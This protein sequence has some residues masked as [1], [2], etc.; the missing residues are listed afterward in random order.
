M[1]N[2]F[3]F[4]NGGSERVF[5][6]ERDFLLKRGAKVIDFSMNDPRNFPSPYSSFFVSNIDYRSS[7]GSWNRICQGGK[8]IHSPG[9]MEKTKKIVRMEKP[10]IAH[11]HNIYHQ[12]TPSIIPL[13]KKHG[14]KTVLTLHDGKLICPGYSMLN[15][16][17][18]CTACAGRHFWKSATKR[19]QDSLAQ[20]V[21]LMLEAYWHKWRGSYQAIDLFIAPSRFMA[22]LTSRRIPRERIRV[23]HNGVRVDEFTPN[24]QDEGYC[25][26]FGR[27][28]KEKGIE[29]LLGVRKSIAD[30]LSL[31][32]VGTGP[33]EE[34]L[35][36]KYPETEFLGYRQGD[37]LND[38][39]AKSAFVIVPSEWY[40]NCSMVVLEAMAMGKPVIGSRMGGIPEQV[41]DGK[42]GMLFEAG[43]AEELKEKLLFLSQN[44]DARKEMGQAARRKTEQEY[45]MES[46]CRKLCD[47]YDELT[48][49]N[50][51]IRN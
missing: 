29:T 25:L 21:L 37:E 3:F 51:P 23:L 38:I 33:I 49:A 34:E 46:H 32:I 24:Y 36:E 19:C 16:G 7:S 43:N 15:K 35:C 28:S 30:K 4:L 9:A 41:E 17:E 47:I 50:L 18:I 1:A 13:L 48:E 12:L 10:D 2:K 6:Q 8:L 42:T 39:I 31:K 45:S 44:P 27:L 11:L 14:V 26:Y 20:G 5:F 40:E 22:D